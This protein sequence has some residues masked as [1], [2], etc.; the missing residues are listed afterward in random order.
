[1]VRQD[2]GVEHI[3][4]ADDDVG[5]GQPARRAGALLGRITVV[6]ERLDVQT[7]RL[8]ETV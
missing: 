3:R 4:V 7:Q 1:M 2:A 6:G 5:P 8:D